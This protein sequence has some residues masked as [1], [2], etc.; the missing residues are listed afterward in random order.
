M[1]DKLDSQDETEEIESEEV[2]EETQDDSD[3]EQ[4]SEEV[5]EEETSEDSDE[6]E[7]SEPDAFDKRFTQF[8]GDTLDEYTKNLEEAYANSTAEY[9]K[10][11]KNQAEQ[12]QQEVPEGQPATDPAL[13]YARQQMET[14]QSQEY[15]AFAKEHP[16]IESDPEV[17]EKMTKRLATLAR[18]V[19]AEDG[20]VLGMAEGL[21]M[22]WAS[23]GL[24]NN[25]QENTR[26]AAKD[27]AATTRTASVKKNSAKPQF[28]QAELEAAKKMGLTEK[29]LI[30]NTK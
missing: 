8:K 28:S 1:A 6:E 10:L 18:T 3:D 19:L 21:S 5:K 26:M 12:R 24:G 25:Q 2:D 9:A 22:A 15:D 30:A 13:L 20:K 29:D 11:T 27:A 4:A 17:G 7:S 23:L 14:Q 16:E